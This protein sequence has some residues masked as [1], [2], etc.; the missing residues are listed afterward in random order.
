MRLGDVMRTQSTPT[1]GI[2]HTLVAVSPRTTN[3]LTPKPDIS[4]NEEGEF[5]FV[6]NSMSREDAATM[7]AS[8]QFKA[9]LPEII[10]ILDVPIPIASGGEILFPKTGYDPRFRSY[11]PPD[12]PVPLE[13]GLDEA[14]D[15]RLPFGK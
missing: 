14:R 8:Q 12:A 2:D 6:A 4:E 3:P 9:Q 10:R 7:L 15:G 5:E 13:I 1:N 11:C